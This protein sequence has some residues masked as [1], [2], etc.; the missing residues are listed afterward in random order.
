MKLDTLTKIPKVLG[1]GLATVDG[2][3]IES[4]FTVGYNAEK[5]GAMAAQVVKTIK[6]SLNIEKVSVI[7]YLQNSV[8]FIKETDAGIFF[9]MCQK[10]A[11]IGLIKIKINKIT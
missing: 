8:F 6:Q 4:Q 11:N 5:S 3:V 9:V 2:F 1:V 10:D 7:F